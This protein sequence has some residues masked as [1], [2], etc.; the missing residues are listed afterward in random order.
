MDVQPPLAY[1]PETVR[2]EYCCGVLLPTDEYTT[3]ITNFPGG[4]CFPYWDTKGDFFLS[5][6]I[7]SDGKRHA[8]VHSKHCNEKGYLEVH[9]D[10]ATQF[11]E[12]PLSGLVLIELTLPKKVPVDLYT[13][14]VHK[15]TGIYVSYPSGHF[16]GDTLYTATRARELFNTG[17]WP[18]LVSS[19]TAETSVI[20]MNPYKIPF[21]YQLS[22]FL[23]DGRKLQTD[24]MKVLPFRF[25]IHAI[26]ETFPEVKNLSVEDRE[27]C[28]ICISSQYNLVGYVMIKDRGT[29]AFTSIDHLHP[30]VLI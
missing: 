21:S 26:E 20:L 24:V 16:V 12:K 13:A 30:Y 18:G 11:S 4:N 3:S 6:S 1:D 27:C 10:H 14:H 28:S 9:I 5:C 19:D 22:L 25:Q 23:P 15:K 17:F 7:F 29:G 2:Q 8:V